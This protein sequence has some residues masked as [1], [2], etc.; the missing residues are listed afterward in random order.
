MKRSFATAVSA[1][2]VLVLGAGIAN[3]QEEEL[4]EPSFRPVE[5]WTCDYRDGKGRA[6]LDKVNAMWNDWMDDTG[7][8]D[9]YAAIITPTFYGERAFDVGWLGVY[10]DGNAFGVGTE[11]WYTEGGEVGAKFGEVVTCSSHTGWVSMNI[12]EPERNDDD[13]DNSFVLSFANCS[14]NEGHTFKEFRQAHATW[15]AYADEHGIK[16][17]SWIWW[18]VAGESNNDYDFKWISGEDDYTAMG[19]NWQKYMDGHWRKSNELFDDIVDCD[20]AR[21]Y[22]GTAIRRMGDDD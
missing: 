6:D 21:V 18:P 1:A 17:G 7:Q 20:I 11:R 10:E 16:D 14:I 22:S 2:C 12:R 3:A 15:N 19:A 4:D 8:N 9:Y 13:S 5:T